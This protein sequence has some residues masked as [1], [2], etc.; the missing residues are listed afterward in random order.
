MQSHGGR[1][2]SSSLLLPDCRA[3]FR[4]KPAVI[5]KQSQLFF[6]RHALIS[7]RG[8]TIALLHGDGWQDIAC[9]VIS[10]EKRVSARG[11]ATNEAI[12]FFLAQSNKRTK[13]SPMIYAGR[14]SRCLRKCLRIS[15]KLARKS[16]QSP[17]G[18]T[19]R[20]NNDAAHRAFRHHPS[21]QEAPA[22]MRCL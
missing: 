14:G 13:G 8:R 17:I 18:E 15:K 7:T 19:L 2:F 10:H 4:P 11:V 16:G 5:L 3:T 21:R 6:R 20:S 12:A 9:Q 1:E 22:E